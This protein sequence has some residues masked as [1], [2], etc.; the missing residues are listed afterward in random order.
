[1]PCPCSVDCRDLF[2]MM[3]VRCVELVGSGVVAYFRSMKLDA[4]DW[5]ET[6]SQDFVDENLA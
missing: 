4:S 3:A 6:R 1:M 5:A 2:D